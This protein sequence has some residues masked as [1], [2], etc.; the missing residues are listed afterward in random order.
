MKKSPP[1]TDQMSDKR[2]GTGLPGI[3]PYKHS[4]GFVPEC[5]AALR[6]ARETSCYRNEQGEERKNMRSK[7]KEPAKI[8]RCS[9]PWDF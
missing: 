5:L 7:S 1:S 6:H 4:W 2:K 9:L 8:I 3:S